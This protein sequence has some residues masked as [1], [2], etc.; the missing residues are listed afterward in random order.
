MKSELSFC[1]QKKKKKQNLSKVA[2]TM[3]RITLVQK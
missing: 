3:Q 2:L 1:F